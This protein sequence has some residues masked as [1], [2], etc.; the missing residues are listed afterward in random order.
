MIR[1]YKRQF[2]GRENAMKVTRLGQKYDLTKRN[3]PNFVT[4]MTKR[5]QG[6]RLFCI[7]VF[8]LLILNQNA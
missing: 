4:F 5:E 8:K 6:N 1:Q 7:F 2:K 3:L